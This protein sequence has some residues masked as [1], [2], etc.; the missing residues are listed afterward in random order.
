[1]SVCRSLS[2]LAHSLTHFRCQ[3]RSE[4]TYTE[5]QEEEMKLLEKKRERERSKAEAIEEDITFKTKMGVSVY[6]VC[7]CMQQYAVYSITII[8][9]CILYMEK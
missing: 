6:F 4:L 3:V 7:A 2:V 8:H 1:M 5:Q 9:T